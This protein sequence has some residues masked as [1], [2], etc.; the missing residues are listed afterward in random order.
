[1]AIEIE[2]LNIVISKK[3][4]LDNITLKIKEHEICAIIGPN[5]A[6][7]STLLKS[8]AGFYKTDRIKLFGK[9]INLYNRRELAK[10]VSLLPQNIAPVPFTLKEFLLFSR[11]P[12]RSLLN[13]DSQ[14]V[15]V[16]KEIMSITGIEELENRR[17]DALSGG[18]LELAWLAASLVT[19]SKILILDEPTNY[20]DPYYTEKLRK[21]V[22]GL[23]KKKTVLIAS[24]NLEWISK[25]ATRIIALRSGAIS[26]QTEKINKNDV[27][28]LYKPIKLSEIEQ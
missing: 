2:T 10:T 8:V 21:I 28:P 18:Q 7:K 26:F 24:H 4:I 16:C 6:G 5:G 23:A 19:E 3:R 17:L 11:Y 25:I 12:Y 20:L 1:M 27:A 9:R 22:L 13:E 15:S 14:A